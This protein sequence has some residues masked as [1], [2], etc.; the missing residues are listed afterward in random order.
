MVSTVVYSSPTA[1]WLHNGGFVFSHTWVEE[2]IGTILITDDPELT[3]LENGSLIV[4]SGVIQ[5][6]QMNKLKKFK[7]KGNRFGLIHLRD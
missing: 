3:S 1:I 6:S 5:H 4:Y 7:K 2:V